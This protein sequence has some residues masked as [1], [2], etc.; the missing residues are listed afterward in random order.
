MTNSQPPFEQPGYSQTSE[1]QPAAVTDTPTVVNAQS[2]RRFLRAAVVTGATAVAVGTSAG[3]VAKA[4]GAHTGILSHFGIVL[5]GSSTNGNCAICFEKKSDYSHTTQCSHSAGTEYALWLTAHNLGPGDYTM[6]FSPD[7]TNTSAPFHLLSTNSHS[8]NASL[9]VMEAN[10]GVDCPKCDSRG[11]VHTNC[12]TCSP[13]N[14]VRQSHTTDGL[15]IKNSNSNPYHI[16]SGHRDLQ[17]LVYLKWDG[18]NLGSGYTF[19]GTVKDG[20][21]STVCQVSLTV[22]SN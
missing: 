8:D 19:T 15:F 13:S 7:P 22:K 17:M 20:N 10:K 4:N 21:G 3:V 12:N 11:Y 5:G 14:P 6:S 9:F 18:T 16:S 2:R 1:T